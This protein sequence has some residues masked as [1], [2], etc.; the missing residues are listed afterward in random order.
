[1][2]GQMTT[3]PFNHAE[4][5]LAIA[6]ASL[7]SAVTSSNANSISEAGENGF[8]IESL[9]SEPR[10]ALVMVVDDEGFNIDLVEAY[11]EDE[12]FQNF[13]TTTDSTSALAMVRSHRPDI[14]LLDVKMPQVT[15][16]EILA[17]MRNDRELRLIPALILTASTAPETKLEALRLGAS[18]FLAKPVD[19]SELAL[20]VKNV[21]SVKAYQDHLAKYSERLEQQVDIRT[22]ELV[23]SR[24]EAIHCLARAGEFRDDDT[25]HHVMRVGLY[26]SIIA[27]ELGFAKAEIELIEQAAQLHDVGKIGIPDAILH[28][29]GKTRASRIRHHQTTLWDWSRYYQSADCR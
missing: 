17:A 22:K 26:S 20:R 24:E 25:G 1:M 27:E 19:P 12:G 5:P 3:Q 14:V 11:L 23:R 6:N 16:L 13:V 15:G 9:D 7:P 18:D 8:E 28:K 10:D 2:L 4:I 21:L 29:P